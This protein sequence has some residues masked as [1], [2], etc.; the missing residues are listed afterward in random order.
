[1]SKIKKPVEAETPQEK[2]LRQQKEAAKCLS[3]IAAKHEVKE[4]YNVFVREDGEPQ[5]EI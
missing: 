4:N 3:D 1:M 2:E 5:I